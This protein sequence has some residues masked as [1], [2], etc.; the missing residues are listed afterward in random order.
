MASA[1]V[2]PLRCVGPFGV[3][4]PNI[5]ASVKTRVMA[6]VLYMAERKEEISMFGLLWL[7]QPSGLSVASVL[8]AFEPRASQ[9]PLLPASVMV[10]LF[11]F[12]LRVVWRLTL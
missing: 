11:M 5:S 7:L 9:P 8:S 6:V 4:V 12:G 2:G 10:C 1:A 3:W